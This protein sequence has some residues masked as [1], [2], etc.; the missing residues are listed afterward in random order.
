[1][2][3][4][5]GSR[6]SIDQP[7]LAGSRP[8]VPRRQATSRNSPALSVL[9]AIVLAAAPAAA[10]V[11]I[12]VDRPLDGD[13]VVSPV[14]VRAEAT[15]DAPGAHVTGWQVFADGVTAYGTG[16]PTSAMAARLPLENGSHEIVVTAQD[17]S[18]DSATAT[19]TIVIG[20]C[21]GFTVTLESPAG[22]SETTP[23]H[24]AA[25]AASCHRITG[26]ALYAD[27][28]EIFQQRGARSLDTNLE[29]PA[30]THTIFAR[31]WDTTGAYAN[32]SAVPVEVA[33]KAPV[34]PPASR[35]PPAAQAQPN[36][37]PPPPR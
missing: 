23:V 28:R 16:G 7:S 19:L 3:R 21:A 10:T 15:T 35:K 25:T 8:K 18:G 20:V 17:S 26:F 6:L 11:T 37:A 33:P 5:F 12:A 32:S 34:Q 36:Q 29:V 2:H 22:G 14:E 9:F 27:D 30:G 4:P 31:A 1:M 13:T 24:F